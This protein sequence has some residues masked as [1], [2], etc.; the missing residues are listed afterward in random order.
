MQGAGTSVTLILW[1]ES[2]TTG[3]PELL[4]RMALEPCTHVPLL[5]PMRGT[6]I[7]GRVVDTPTHASGQNMSSEYSFLAPPIMF[8]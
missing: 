8:G 2:W 4:P 5:D 1:A 7:V 6:A 3:W